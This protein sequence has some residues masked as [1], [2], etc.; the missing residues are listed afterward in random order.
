[1]NNQ[2]GIKK[3]KSL[4]SIS[5]LE[6]TLIRVPINTNTKIKIIE[7]KEIIIETLKKL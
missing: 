3:N 1:M 7:D 5:L 4:T 2:S 6:I